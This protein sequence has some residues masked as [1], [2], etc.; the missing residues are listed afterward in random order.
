M[1]EARDRSAW[2]RTAMLAYLIAAT[3][4]LVWGCEPPFGPERFDPYAAK[5]PEAPDVT[6]DPKKSVEFL[7]SVHG[8]LP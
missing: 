6:L 3:P 7:A 5:K 2:D 1:A 8:R 4:A